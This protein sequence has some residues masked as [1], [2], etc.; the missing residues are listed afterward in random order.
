ML[1][2]LE[3]SIKKEVCVVALLNCALLL[4]LLWRSHSSTKTLSHPSRSFSSGG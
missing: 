3:T 1:I 2:F 4:V